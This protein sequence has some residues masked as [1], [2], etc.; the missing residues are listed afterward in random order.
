MN[1][2]RKLCPVV[3]LAKPS[4]PLV[5]STVLGE[6]LVI[7]FTPTVDCSEI[8]YENL[9]FTTIRKV[10]ANFFGEMFDPTYVRNL[11]KQVTDENKTGWV[12]YLP[13]T[14]AVEPAKMVFGE[15]EIPMSFFVGRGDIVWRQTLHI[16]IKKE[17]R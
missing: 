9:L 7:Y 6:D 13:V 1:G 14:V 10:G 15:M 8:P 16:P 5:R 2:K 17:S 11:I 3:E 12:L 4:L